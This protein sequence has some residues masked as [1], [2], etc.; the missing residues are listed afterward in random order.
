MRNRMIKIWVLL[1]LVTGCQFEENGTKARSPEKADAAL[2]LVQTIPLDGVEGRIDHMA[3][4]AKRDRLFVAALG[5]NTVEVIDL[6]A[7]KRLEPIKD[8]KKPQGVVYLADADRL[9]VASGDD[10]KCRVYDAGLKLLGTVDG[11][12]DADN[13]RY[14]PQSKLAYV[15]YGDGA[16]AVLDPV[17]IAKIADIK[18]EGHPESFQLEAKGKRIFVNVPTARQVAVIDRKK[19]S[20]E[21]KWPITQAEANFPMALDED[22]LRLLIGCRKPARL[23][24]INVESGKVEQSLECSGDTDDLFIDATRQRIYVAGGTGTVSVFTIANDRTLSTLA[25]ITTADGARTA[26]FV[27]QLSKLFVAVPRRAGQESAIKIYEPV[28]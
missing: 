12:D 23:L 3:L 28:K 22:N 10:G 11:L 2:R 5:N 20:V 24:V 15:G 9:L 16:L 8:I 27:P 21:A 14:D 18:L 13:V 7:G 4:D 26:L 19:Q 17:K 6:K 25:T 1:S